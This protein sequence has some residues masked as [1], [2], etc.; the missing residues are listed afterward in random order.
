MKHYQISFRNDSTGK[1]RIMTIPES[2]LLNAAIA[3]DDMQNNVETLISVTE[4]TD[5]LTIN[6]VQGFQSGPNNT[7][8]NHF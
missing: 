6:G 8:I 2:T 4:T 1:I 3:A 5:Y 7:Q